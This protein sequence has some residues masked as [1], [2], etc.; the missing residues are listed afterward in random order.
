LTCLNL[1]CGCFAII[2]IFQ[3]EFIYA[4]YLVFAAAVID[5][6]DGFA[7]RMLKAY[8]VIGKDLDSLADMVTFGVV[9]G[10]IMYQLFQK[11]GTDLTESTSGWHTELSAI[12]NIGITALLIP[13]FSAIRLAKFNNDTRQ[14][15]SFIGLPTPANAMLICSLPFIL[16]PCLNMQTAS[17]TDGISCYVESLFLNPWLFVG[18]CCLMSFLLVAELPLFSLKFKTFVFKGNEIRYVMI[19]AS[20]I[21]LSTLK[22]AGIPVII[23]LYILL[24]II[25]NIFFKK[26]NKVHFK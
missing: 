10:V 7:A 15:E 25:N 26:E 22:F 5:F 16:E 9:P 8:S 12:D 18:F 2:L 19:A 11:I 4:A 1:L 24:S 13:L 17:C 23:F 6:F 3:N 20:V 21:L 14:T